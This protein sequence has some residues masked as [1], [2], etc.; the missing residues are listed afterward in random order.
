LR[1]KLGRAADR[2]PSP[3]DIGCCIESKIWQ[4]TCSL[5]TNNLGIATR[6]SGGA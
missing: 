1:N 5:E 3:D 2:K 6:P 4:P